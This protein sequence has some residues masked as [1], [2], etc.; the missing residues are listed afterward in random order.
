MQAYLGY[1]SSI[2]DG[3]QLDSSSP[4]DS[5]D[6]ARI[7]G[8]TSWAQVGGY[9]DGDG[10]IHLRTDSPVVLRFALVWVDNYYEQLSQLRSFLCSRNI[11]LGSVLEQG[12]GVFRLQIASPRFALVAAKEMV[13]FCFKKK[14][15]LKILIDY[16]EDRVTGT[17]AVSNINEM[18]RR[19]I[20]LGGL[21]T[22]R[23]ASKYSEGKHS[24]ARARG[25]RA[26]EV[27]W[28]REQV[29]RFRAQADTRRT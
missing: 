8:Y 15:E 19:R 2:T 11:V 5:R 20:R 7:G 18:V 21:R 24:V 10:C 16:Y 22:V 14:E 25:I 28:E 23:I 27:R 12:I 13:P 26:A 29:G 17:E 6:Y 9:F 4:P 1:V 3:R